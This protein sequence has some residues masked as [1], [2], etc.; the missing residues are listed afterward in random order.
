MYSHLGLWLLGCGFCLWISLAAA[1]QKASNLAMPISPVTSTPSVHSPDTPELLL[2]QD[3]LRLSSSASFWRDP[4]GRAKVGAVS[5]HPEWFSAPQADPNWGFAPESAYWFRFSLRNPTAQ[6]QQRILF[7]DF[8]LLDHVYLYVPDG[9]GSFKESRSGDTEPWSVRTIKVRQLALPF[10]VPAMASTTYFVRIESSSNIIFPARIYTPESFWAHIS[11]DQLWLGMFY[12]AMLLLVV[13]NLFLYVS[14]REK[15]FLVYACALMPS[16]AYL[17]CID[18]LTFQFIPV[19]G[20]LQNISLAFFIGL[21]SFL[22]L[23]F[24]RHY[25]SVPVNSAWHRSTKWLMLLGLASLLLLPLLGATYGSIMVLLSGA[26]TS[27]YI[28]LMAFSALPRER[29]VAIYFVLGWSIF[30]INAIAAALAVFALIPLLDFFIL[31]IKVGLLCTATLISMGMGLHMRMLKRL[32]AKSR[33]DALLAEAKSQ[34]RSQFLAMMSHEIR[35]PMNGV[36]GMTELLKTTGLNNEQNRILATME[37]SGN[38]LLEVIDDVLDHAK[39]ESGRMELELQPLDLD[40]LMEECL[41]LFKARIYKQQLSLL[42]SISPDVPTEIVGDVLRL[43]QIITNLLSNAV[44]FTSHGGIEVAV[45]AFAEAGAVQLTIAVSDTGIGI[46]P[47]QREQIFDSFMQADIFA[48]RYY[49]G[50]GLGLSISRE[51]C[52][53]MGGDL[54][55]ES[56]PGR[57]SVFYARIRVSPLAGARPRAVWPTDLPPVRLL[58]VEGYRRFDA[59]MEAEASTPGF[60]VE[61]V[62]TGEAAF[63][64][65]HEA[66]KAGQPFALVA[67]ALQLPDMNGLTLHGR[68]E[69]DPALSGCQTLLFAIPQMQPSPGVLV[70]AG[71]AHAFERPVFARELRQ[72]ALAVLRRQPDEVPPQR[73]AMP[74][75]QSLRVLVAEDN[76]TN[77]MVIQ[78]MLQRFGIQADL[79]ENGEQA[80]AACRRAKHAYNLVLMDCEM[81][82]MDGYAAAREIRRL[83][84]EEGHSR[85]PIIAISAHVTQHHIDNCYAAG[86]DDHIPKP[87]NLRLLRDKLEQWSAIPS[88]S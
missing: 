44:K 73:V 69:H 75:Y 9:Q 43:R 59:V 39:I 55:V 27:T 68:I 88:V 34:T 25:L 5:Q 45:T 78:G 47:E 13:Y 11:Q 1:E 71:V 74:Q 40:T 53:L 31:G 70:H 48:S 80:L 84:T 21:S 41:D 20:L 66:A 37:A 52:Q 30:L 77:Q 65:L 56:E 49:G 10:A 17:L 8:P 63:Q 62:Q 28:L 4:T 7:I 32:E 19:V 26:V 86:M 76:R 38:A 35:T 16:I 60:A 36:L 79:V 87:V 29:T 22:Y 46:A 6:V 81:P 85:I 42:C 23:N 67:T 83:E 58:L 64:R 14:A 61:S 57:G 18:G 12:G 54:A 72:A 82:I 15:V 50:T 51:L 2:D 24:A 33:E 3:S